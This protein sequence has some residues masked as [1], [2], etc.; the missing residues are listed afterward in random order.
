MNERKI[1][2]L[3]IAAVVILMGAG[4]GTYAW[5]TSKAASNPKT[6]TAGKLVIDVNG[7]SG[8]S[9]LNKFDIP[10]NT[11]DIKPGDKLT[12]GEGNIS[13][14]T[15]KNN[16]TL[17]MVTLGR[18]NIS[19]INP[20]ADLSDVMI[21]DQYKIE[22][23]DADG[24]M[25]T[26]KVLVSDGTVSGDVTG[27]TTRADNK[28]TLRNLIDMQDPFGKVAGWKIDGLKKGEQ[29]V[30][31]FKLIMDPDAGDAYQ[32]QKAT[33]NYEI[34]ATQ[35]NGNAISNLGLAGLNA[36]EEKTGAA[37]TAAINY[38]K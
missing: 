14:I 11:N 3:V 36:D 30:I 33:L 34:R 29:M 18:F 21:I 37:I 24:I 38:A 26:E 28:A 35:P 12:A 13:T 8:E 32:G 17:P 10:F 5:F 16:G 23:K 25:R 20:E 7:S 22:Y 6:F 9:S 19:D 15:I 31:S 2:I 27:F 4:I 1:I